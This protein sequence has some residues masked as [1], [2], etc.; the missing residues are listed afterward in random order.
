MWDTLCANYG[1]G[2]G[3]HRVKKHVYMSE[4]IVLPDFLIDGGIEF[5][6]VVASQGLEYYS[7]FST[8]QWSFFE[9]LPCGDAHWYISHQPTHSASIQRML[10][11]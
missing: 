2:F 3:R 11:E 5:D 10:R 7:D 4:A 8:N 1:T 6:V 9:A